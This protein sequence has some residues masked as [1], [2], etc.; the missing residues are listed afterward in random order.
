[1][2]C[3]REIDELKSQVAELEAQLRRHSNGERSGLLEQESDVVRLESS[4]H[5]S[6]RRRPRNVS[7]SGA[8]SNDLSHIDRT[9][10]HCRG[11]MIE[12]STGSIRH[13]YGLSSLQNLV[14]SLRTHLYLAYGWVYTEENLYPKP[15]T[16]SFSSPSGQIITNYPTT[17]RSP[18]GCEEGVFMGK[19]QEEECLRL[20]WQSYH[21]A[22][23]IL[24]ERKFQEHHSSLWHDSSRGDHYRDDSALVDV[25]LAICVQYG[26]THVQGNLKPIEADSEYG[27]TDP[28]NAG[29][30]YFQRSQL[31][32]RAEL[33]KPSIALLQCQLFSI[34]YLRD[35]SLFNL[36]LSTAASAVQTAY[37]LGLH[38][39]VKESSD[40][41]ER[42]L[43]KRLWC[44]VFVLEGKMSMDC[45]RPFLAQMIS[46]RLPQDTHELASNSTEM[47]VPSSR[48][49][50]T[51]L[52]Y[53][54]QHVKLIRTSRKVFSKVYNHAAQLLASKQGQNFGQETEIVKKCDEIL[55][56]E[57]EVL[58][59]WLEGVPEELR[60]HSTV[61]EDA[62]N[63]RISR[64]DVTQQN[65]LWLQRQRVMLRLL[66]HDIC[67]SLCRAFV[68]FPSPNETI[69]THTVS[70]EE[71]LQHAITITDIVYQVLKDSDILFGWHRAYQF[72]W[73]AALLM[74]AFAFANLASPLIGT[75]F[76]KLEHAIFVL[77][78]FGRCFAVARSATEIIRDLYGKLQ[79]AST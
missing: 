70:A 20:F 29:R 3:F 59:L 17:Y 4:Q 13:F 12:T 8:E 30:W 74:I 23:P 28:S 61:S 78:T 72:Q 39:D 62:M 35:A 21:C 2:I 51:W 7:S 19:D 14:H 9:P 54:V 43:L 73:N 64:T 45:G 46:I 69:S 76:V 68:I 77:D 25:I 44:M 50:V 6:Q 22:I 37:A 36:A 15:I 49:K 31:L 5:E 75:I 41:H 38:M 57:L 47:F 60:Y 66:Y 71:C 58:K 24:D 65:P 79:I 56:E 42:E 26:M 11:I 63:G 48:L 10:L 18:G 1:M 55:V 52:T 27:V 32:L 34:V 33:D 16:L 53:H 40:I 67:I